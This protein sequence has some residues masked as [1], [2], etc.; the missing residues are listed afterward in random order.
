MTPSKKYFKLLHC[1]M[2][3]QNKYFL[4]NRQLE[5][6]HVLF[7]ISFKHCLRMM[8]WKIPLD[9]LK[10]QFSTW[11]C[12]RLFLGEHLRFDSFCQGGQNIHQ[13]ARL[14]FF[15]LST[16][17]LLS[18]ASSH[19]TEKISKQRFWLEMW[20]ENLIWSHFLNVDGSYTVTEESG[21]RIICSLSH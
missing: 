4:F 8:Y 21:E 18:F 7:R 14:G 6:K 9:L 20:Y 15:I 5:N 2:H 19:C 13:L 12:V 3:T 1:T 16:Q 10:I 17:N 11:F